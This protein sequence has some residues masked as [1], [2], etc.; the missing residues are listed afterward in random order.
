MDESSL[1]RAAAADDSAMLVCDTCRGYGFR[2]EIAPGRSVNVPAALENGLM[3]V[4]RRV[5]CGCQPVPEE[6][7]APAFESAPKPVAKKPQRPK[8]KAKKKKVTVAGIKPVAY[9]DAAEVLAS[10]D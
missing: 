10:G 3:S 4:G 6:I 1:R 8:P 9:V 5:L 2:V 7:K